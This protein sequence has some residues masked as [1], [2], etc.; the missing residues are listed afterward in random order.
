VESDSRTRGQTCR[1][2]VGNGQ[3]AQETARPCPLDHILPADRGRLGGG[4]C[5]PDWARG[6]RRSKR[7]PKVAHCFRNPRRCPLGRRNVPVR[8]ILEGC[9]GAGVGQSACSFRGAQARPYDGPNADELLKMERE[10]IEG[11]L[12]DLCDH[13]A[14]AVEK[15]SAPR[16]ELSPEQHRERRVRTRSTGILKR[17]TAI[18]KLSNAS[19]GL[20]LPSLRSPP[21]LLRSRAC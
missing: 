15:G 1:Y 21:S 17:L 18:E 14:E 20:K 12:A 9:T 8:P 7:A 19:A 11:P 16:S 4:D 3:S 13:Q 2:L 6:G 10:K 5:K